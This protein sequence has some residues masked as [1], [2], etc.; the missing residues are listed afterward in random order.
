MLPPTLLKYFSATFLVL[1]LGFTP[2]LENAFAQDKAQPQPG[3]TNDSAEL[4]VYEQAQG[5]WLQCAEK[6]KASTSESV[7]GDYRV[8][9]AVY[10]ALGKAVGSN[11]YGVDD[12]KWLYFYMGR[13]SASMALIAL[14]VADA[15][16]SETA[17]ASVE[18]AD[19]TF[20]KVAAEKSSWEAEV[21]T[22]YEI[23]SLVKT[24][25]GKFGVPKWR[26]K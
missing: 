9:N 26:Q 10:N 4:S 19:W 14:S 1:G 11:A 15:G 16:V 20:Q 22:Q 23:D 8:C 21:I 5:L 24:C 17:C 12:V 7:E 2:L 18:R 25:R 13:T 3:T 6:Q